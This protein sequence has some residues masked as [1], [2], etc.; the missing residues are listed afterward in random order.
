MPIVLNNCAPLKQFRKF[1]A[2]RIGTANPLCL[3]QSMESYMARYMGEVVPSTDDDFP[4]IAMISDED[5]NVVG[6]F[7][8]RTAADGE[9]KIVEALADLK[10]RDERDEEARSL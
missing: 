2:Y 6:E 10:K 1:D 7:P 3:S 4:F 8:V 9:A 5:G